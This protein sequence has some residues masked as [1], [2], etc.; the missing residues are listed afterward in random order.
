MHTIHHV[1]QASGPHK[2]SDKDQDGCQI[3]QVQ[4][5]PGRGTAPVIWHMVI[6]CSRRA[7]LLGH[8]VCGFKVCRLTSCW[9]YGVSDCPSSLA[10]LRFLIQSG[11]VFR[12]T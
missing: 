8:I 10:V 5:A 3:P 1:V 7:R 9:D 2:T 11:V 12:S 6:K 4:T